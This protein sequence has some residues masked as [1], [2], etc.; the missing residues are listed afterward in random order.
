MKKIV[1][2]QSIQSH[3]TDGSVPP[4]IVFEE[5]MTILLNSILWRSAGSYSIMLCSLILSATCCLQCSHNHNLFFILK[6]LITCQSML[7]P[8]QVSPIRLESFQKLPF[9]Q[10]CFQKCLKSHLKKIKRKNE[11]F[12]QKR[13]FE[14]EFQSNLVWDLEQL[15]ANLSP[16]NWNVFISLKNR[17]FIEHFI[18]ELMFS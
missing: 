7:S 13:S 17:G 8:F 6:N 9:T 5:R 10:L 4:V 12:L 16:S 2:R 11:F 14:F 18:K 15:I 3:K 1:G